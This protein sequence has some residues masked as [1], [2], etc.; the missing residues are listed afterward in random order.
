[1]DTALRAAIEEHPVVDTSTHRRTSGA[2]RHMEF[3]LWHA[4]GRISAVARASPC[5]AVQVD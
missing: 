3:R 4:D 2:T 5:G 1:M